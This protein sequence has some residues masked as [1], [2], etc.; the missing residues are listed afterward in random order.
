MGC[1]RGQ[2]STRSCIPYSYFP[3]PPGREY[4]LT[5]SIHGDIAGVSPRVGKSGKFLSCK[6]IPDLYASHS[7]RCG[8]VRAIPIQGN[9]TACATGRD[10]KEFTART[11]IPKS[12]GSIIAAGDQAFLILTEGDSPDGSGMTD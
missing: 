2:Q 5:R 3:I 8:E 4:P 9:L 12:H 7:I 11:Y 10:G 6:R 1:Y